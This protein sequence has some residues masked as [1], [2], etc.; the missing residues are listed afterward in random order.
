ARHVRLAAA[1]RNWLVCRLFRVCSS[2]WSI[3][4]KIVV[5]PVRVRVS[6][7]SRPQ[8]RWLLDFLVLGRSVSRTSYTTRGNRGRF[9]SSSETDNPH[10][11]GRFRGSIAAVVAWTIRPEVAAISFC[12]LFL[13]AG[14]GLA[15]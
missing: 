11:Y 12:R 2:V 14:R 13:E 4:L 8:S 9:S 10:V 6:P 7:F 3:C 1:V 15:P 5:S